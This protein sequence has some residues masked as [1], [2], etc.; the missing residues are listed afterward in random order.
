VGPNYLQLP[1]N[2]AKAG[3]VRTNQRDGA[4]AYHVDGGG[5]NPSVNY[6]PSITGGLTEAPKPAHEAQGP[7]LEGRLTRARI[8]RTND[9]QQAGE[10]YL[11]SEPWE[12]D[13][14]VA[15]LVDAL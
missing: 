4:M 1:V 10:R 6:E 5:E 15:N 11:L 14:L 12:R 2:Q 13:D 3:Q 9:Y 8:P 7:V